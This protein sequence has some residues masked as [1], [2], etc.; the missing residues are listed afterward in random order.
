MS[1]TYEEVSVTLNAGQI[2]M[3]V[4]RPKI[5]H[6]KM[7]QSNESPSLRL[8]HI[9][10]P[11][12][13]KSKEMENTFVWVTILNNDNIYNDGTIWKES[14]SNRGKYLIRT[15]ISDPNNYYYG[16]S[17]ISLSDNLGQRQY[18]VFSREKQGF[19]FYGI[20]K[21]QNLVNNDGKITINYTRIKSKF[22]YKIK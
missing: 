7:F 19:I 15:L 2:V 17:N 8:T 4:C 12:T 6:W 11:I 16:L 1:N 21:C 14:I 18:M 3:G 13:F 10:K 20:Y 22:T 9:L 5:F